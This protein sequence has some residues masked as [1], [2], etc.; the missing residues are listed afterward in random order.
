MHKQK[1]SATDRPSRCMYGHATPGMT[2]RYEACIFGLTQA[3]H[4]RMR[5]AMPRPHPGTWAGAATTCYL[6][7]GSVTRPAKSPPASRSLLK[8]RSLPVGNTLTLTLVSP[9]HPL[10]APRTP[11]MTMTRK[12]REE[13]KHRSNTLM[14]FSFPT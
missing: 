5:Q 1:M 10:S 3:R 2:A 14:T 7:T 11:P 13:G 9:L 8:Q 6:K 4:G 12:P